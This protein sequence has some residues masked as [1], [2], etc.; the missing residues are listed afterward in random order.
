M[1]PTMF[2]IGGHAVFSYWLLFGFAMLGGALLLLALG[3]G[4]E[5]QFQRM[6]WVCLAAVLA[7]FVSARVGHLFFGTTLA[8]SVD[9]SKGGQL[10][11][12]GLWGAAVALAIA[13]R[14]L[15]LRVSDVM[16]VAAP[17]VFLAGGIQ[18]VGCFLGGCCHGPV[19]SSALACRFPKYLNPTGD[20]VGSPCFQSHL[21]RGLVTQGDAYSLPVFPVQLVSSAIWILLA[22]VLV[23]LVVRGVLRG[24]LLWVSLIAYGAVRFVIQWYRPGYG[25]AGLEGWNGGHTLS[26]V[27]FGAGLFGLVLSILLARTRGRREARVPIETVQ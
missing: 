10:S 4:R 11:F 17:S 22:A 19:S 14:A 8:E 15:R 23:V 12:G 25:G 21:A 3:N 26:L 6:W 16:D 13:A 5:L 7:A 1:R 24:K 9:Y 18:R 20:I 27:T 2:T